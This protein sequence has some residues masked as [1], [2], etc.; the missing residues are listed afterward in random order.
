MPLRSVRMKRL[1]FGFHLRVWCPKWTPLSS[2][3]R[4]VTTAMAVLLFWRGIAPLAVVFAPDRIRPASLVPGTRPP[5]EALWDRWG[6]MP[7][8]RVRGTGCAVGTRSHP[9]VRGA[10]P[11]YQQAIPP[12]GTGTDRLPTASSARA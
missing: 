4:M 12:H 7:R 5:A 6:W 2:S 11:V 3:W 8:I 9:D 10:V 1:T